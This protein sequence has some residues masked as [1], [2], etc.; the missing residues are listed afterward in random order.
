VVNGAIASV[1]DPGT[2]WI[3]ND[4]LL[5]SEEGFVSLEI[6]AGAVVDSRD[7]KVAGLV[8]VTGGASQWT[9]TRDLYVGAFGATGSLLVEGGAACSCDRIVAANTPAGTAILQVTGSGS[10]FAAANDI[11]FAEQGQGA[12][13]ISGAASFHAATNFVTGTFAGSNGDVLSIGSPMTV[14]QGMTLAGAGHASLSLLQGSTLSVGGTYSQG[15]S[16]ELTVEVASSWVPVQVALTA[17][18]NG[19][20]EILLADGFDPPRGDFFDLLTA[21]SVTGAFSTA[22]LPVTPG[23]EQLFIDY[24]PDRVRIYSGPAPADINGDATVNTVDFLLLLK[25]WGPCADCQSCPADLDGDCQVG[26]TDLLLLLGN[27]G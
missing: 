2:H 22:L 10:E 4:L 8:V 14:G 27:W 18:L 16:G 24:L 21:A 15:A 12:L 1:S 5:D 9:M 26:V 23:G 20:L 13:T 19:T 25:A 7:G 11:S 17:T 6:S 3:T